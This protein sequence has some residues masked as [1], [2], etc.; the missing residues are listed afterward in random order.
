[1]HLK[2][3]LKALVKEVDAALSLYLPP[4]SV[5]PAVIHQAMRYSIFAGGK[6]LRP[7][8]ALAACRAVNGDEKKVMPAACALEMVHTY[9]LIHDDLPA[10]DDD[11]L[12]RGQPTNHKV[13]GEA[14]AIL[15]GDA[16]LTRSFGLLAEAGCKEAEWPSLYLQVMR[17][18]AEA[19]GS[20]GM[21][22]GQVVDM[23]SEQK[24]IDFPTMEYIHKHKTGALI[25][26]SLSIG[27]LLGGGS[28][29]QIE[30]L[31]QYGEHLGLAF[32][33]TDDLLD[34][35]GDT[36]KLGKPVGSDVKNQKAT[37][38]ALLGVEEA[39]EKARQAVGAA[40]ASLDGFDAKADF[41]RELAKY[42]LVRED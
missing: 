30:A 39:K 4:E 6:R 14:I 18:L 32:Q 13:F 2:E 24:Q 31:S 9:S 36:E 37:Y 1:M 26:A 11:D 28:E 8:L 27:S 12:R 15:A 23:E 41:L 21:I 7:I 16:L 34:I 3:E 19:S 17:E 20:G 25:R 10:M 22:G 38:P 40:L 42:L 35:Q 5:Y 29:E 33:I